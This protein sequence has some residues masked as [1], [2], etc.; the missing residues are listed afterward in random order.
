MGG[1]TD[2]YEKEI[3][4]GKVQGWRKEQADERK[5][6]KGHEMAKQ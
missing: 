6:E 5:N 1:P 3:K 4:M 2:E